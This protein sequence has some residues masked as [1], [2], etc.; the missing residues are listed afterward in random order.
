MRIGQLSKLSGVSVRMLRYYEQEGLLAPPRKAS[1]YRDYDKGHLET[2]RRVRQ[3]NEAGLR[4]ETIRRF[5]PCVRG[6]RPEFDP[7]PDLIAAL[8][9]EIGRLDDQIA[10]LSGSRRMLNGYL[11]SM[12]APE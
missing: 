4:L 1:G 2:V 12:T 3:L 11:Q 5:L 8:D 6:E 7:C 9:G 10:R